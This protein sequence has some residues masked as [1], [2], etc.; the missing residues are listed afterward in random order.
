MSRTTFRLITSLILVVIFSC[1][2]LIIYGSIVTPSENMP[3][4]VHKHYATVNGYFWDE[5]PVTGHMFG[6]HESYEGRGIIKPETINKV[7]QSPEDGQRA[8]VLLQIAQYDMVS[9]EGG[10]IL[11]ELRAEGVD[12]LD[13]LELA[14]ARYEEQ[15]DH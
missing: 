2:G 10:A 11:E 8:L 14:R 13:L 12:E 1:V 7:E 5:C 4:F 9:K 15:H 3:R 6:G